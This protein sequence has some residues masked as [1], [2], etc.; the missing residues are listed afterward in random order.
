[1]QGC[2]RAS[3]QR[4]MTIEPPRPHDH[5]RRNDDRRPHD[6]RHHVFRRPTETITDVRGQ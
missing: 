6:V 4:A 3:T 1:M 5:N 2:G